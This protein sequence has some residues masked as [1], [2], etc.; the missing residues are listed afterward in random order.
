LINKKG[1]ATGYI[2]L[3]VVVA[4]VVIYIVLLVVF[5]DKIRELLKKFTKKS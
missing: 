4:L 5:E 3:I 1:L 2:V